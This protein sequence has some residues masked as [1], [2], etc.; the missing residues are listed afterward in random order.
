MGLVLVILPIM[1]F[2]PFILRPVFQLWLKVAHAIGWFNTQ[3]LLSIVFI[4]IF[5]PTGLVMRLFRKDPMKRKT[6]AEGTYWE[7]YSLE[8]VKDK[9]RYERQF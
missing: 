9:S 1:A 3:V 8:G 5:I 6:L 4:F 7:P 2:S